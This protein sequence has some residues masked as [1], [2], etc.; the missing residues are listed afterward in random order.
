[1]TSVSG[2]ISAGVINAGLGIVRGL[3]DSWQDS[4]DKRRMK[5]AI[6]EIV[7]DKKFHASFTEAVPVPFMRCFMKVAIILWENKIM[8][9][10][11]SDEFIDNRD[12]YISKIKNYAEF[13]DRDVAFKLIK[14][15]LQQDP[16]N[17]LIYT[18]AYSLQ[19][20]SN[21]D[22]IR[23]A[24]YFDMWVDYAFE[25]SNSE[26]DKN[27]YDYVYDYSITDKIADLESEFAEYKKNH[28]A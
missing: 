9:C 1:M 21:Y 7:F 16:Y 2:E 15:Y 26:D 25:I 5:K 11:F 28:L 20:D 24:D 19:G 27:I 14:D 3:K 18:L 23:L 17:I 10:P 8:Q 4:D 12:A 6:D 22:L 13:G